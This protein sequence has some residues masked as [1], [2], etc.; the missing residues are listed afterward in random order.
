ME[1]AGLGDFFSLPNTSKSKKAKSGLYGGWG[2][3]QKWFREQNVSLY[4]QG[5]E[6]LIVLYDMYLNKSEII[7]KNRGLMS[8]DIRAL[9]LSPL[10]SIHV[11]KLTF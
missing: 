8:K 4:R 2:G 6:N 10:T 3:V 9:F 1:I 7:W 5:L 11:K